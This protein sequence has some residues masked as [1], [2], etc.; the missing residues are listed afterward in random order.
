MFLTCLMLPPL[1]CRFMFRF[2][3]L[4]VLISSSFNLFQCTKHSFFF[5]C[6][7]TAWPIGRVC[8]LLGYRLDPPC[9]LSARMISHDDFICHNFRASLNVI[10]SVLMSID[11]R[12]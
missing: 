8:V 1:L 11:L 6:A 7:C 4:S 9:L 3:F 10:S 5:S 12:L 2:S